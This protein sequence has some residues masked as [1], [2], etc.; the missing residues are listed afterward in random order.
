MAWGDD[1]EAVRAYH[2][3]WYA[4]NKEKKYKA[5][6]KWRTSHPEAHAAI[7]RRHYVK[8]MYGLTVHE[9][10][11]LLTAQGGVCGHCKSAP[12]EHR[13]LSIDHDHKTGAVRG[14][15]C[16]GCNT[17]VSY[18]ERLEQNPTLVCS[19][20]EYLKG[21]TVA[22]AMASPASNFGKRMAAARAA[23]R[24]GSP[25]KG[26]AAKKGQ[27]VKKGK[28]K[29]GKMPPEVIAMFQKKGGK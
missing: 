15:L 19:I 10:M 23:K 21:E 3:Q 26:K 8:K 2:R 11:S 20:R 27:A 18:F 9:Y 13:P 4:E 28:G 25:V 17:L 14:L 5:T 16:D 12:L 6:K 22:K 24:G 1:K 7:Q 29:G